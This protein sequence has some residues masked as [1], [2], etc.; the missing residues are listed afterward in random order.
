MLEPAWAQAPLTVRRLEG[1]APISLREDPDLLA[2][3][4]AG[5]MGMASQLLMT[6][7][8]KPFFWLFQCQPDRIVQL[9]D[10]LSPDASGYRFLAPVF[11]ALEHRPDGLFLTPPN[12]GDMPALV[13][14]AQMAADSG[15]FLRLYAESARFLLQANTIRHWRVVVSRAPWPSHRRPAS[16]ARSF[17]CRINPALTRVMALA[18]IRGPSPVSS[19]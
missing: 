1:W 10:D 6:A 4:M 12:R 8:E 18:T 19:P 17:L 9:L 14:E 2:G 16:T 3:Q 7:S 13:L 15:F 5:R 11:K